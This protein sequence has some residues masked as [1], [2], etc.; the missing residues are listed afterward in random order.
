M[1]KSRT[2][3]AIKKLMGLQAKTAVVVRDGR[4][5]EVLIKD[6]DVND[7]VIVKPGEKI[8]VDGE[9]TEGKVMLM[10]R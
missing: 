7:I 1:A 8:P 9:V 5:I 6:V 10:S 3:E 4:E 2:S